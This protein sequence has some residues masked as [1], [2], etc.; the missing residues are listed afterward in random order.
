MEPSSIPLLSFKG[1]TYSG[2]FVIQS[3]ER[4]FLLSLPILQY[5]G[6]LLLRNPG[7]LH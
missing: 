2:K 5:I 4:H 6:Q 7:V 3:N 1:L